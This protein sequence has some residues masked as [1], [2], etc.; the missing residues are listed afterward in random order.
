VDIIKDFAIDS[1][2][3]LFGESGNVNKILDTME[4]SN[5]WCHHSR[6]PWVDIDRWIATVKLPRMF[7]R[8]PRAINDDLKRKATEN[9]SIAFYLLIP[10]A[11]SHGTQQFQRFILSFAEAVRG[12]YQENVSQQRLGQLEKLFEDVVKYWRLFNFEAMTI[13]VHYLLEIVECVRNFGPC[14]G[15][16]MFPQESLIGLLK[17]RLKGTH[18]FESQTAFYL[19]VFQMNFKAMR[20]LDG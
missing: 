16:H 13:T 2:H 18:S 10:I 8:Q 20:L 9:M 12:I 11:V 6:N 15:W 19:K 7:P 5:S 17:N 14:Q 4:S 3:C 1:M